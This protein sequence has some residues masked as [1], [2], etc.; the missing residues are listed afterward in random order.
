M[1]P[2]A[3]QSMHSHNTRFAL[4]LFA[5]Y[6]ILYLGFM[7][8]S[9]FEPGL[10]AKPIFAGVNLAIVYGM[11]LIFAAFVLALVYALGCKPSATDQ[12]P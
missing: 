4:V 12:T 11:G 5:I 10:M 1:E 7:G 8:I 3:P 6:L 9:A 2:S